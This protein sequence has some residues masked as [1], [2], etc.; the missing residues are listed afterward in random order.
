LL[1]LQAAISDFWGKVF[2]AWQIYP[3]ITVG[4]EQCKC[5]NPTIAAFFSY[6]PSSFESIEVLTEDRARMPCP[7]YFLALVL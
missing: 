2:L 7:I 1:I 6:M 4:Y 5:L 3:A